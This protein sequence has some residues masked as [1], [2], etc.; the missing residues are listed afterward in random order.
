MTRLYPAYARQIAYRIRRGQ[1]PLAVGVMFSS[2]WSDF[3]DVPRL[4]L[5]PDEWSLGRY[6]F[7]Y[8]RGER[9][10]L[11]VG[12]DDETHAGEGRSIGELLCELMLVGPSLVWVAHQA[13]GWMEQTGTP[14]ALADLAESMRVPRE[15]AALARQAYTANYLSASEREAA[16]TIAAIEAGRL[17]GPSELRAVEERFGNPFWV[18]DAQA[19]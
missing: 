5:R 6:E 15:L 12:H 9:V 7:S 18:G 4:C 8:L 19:A 17:P 14:W 1:H 13:G 10:V 16:R 2:F 11:I 3:L